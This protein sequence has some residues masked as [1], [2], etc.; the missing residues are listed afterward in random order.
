MYA[1]LRFAAE[2]GS[3]PMITA[4]ANV[5]AKAPDRSTPI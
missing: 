4:G 5:N 3:V 2:A 1:P